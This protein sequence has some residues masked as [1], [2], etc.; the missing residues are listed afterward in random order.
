MSPGSV[1]SN[2]VSE[3]DLACDDGNAAGV[4]RLVIVISTSC[5]TR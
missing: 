5:P 2:W 1:E 3:G 4:W